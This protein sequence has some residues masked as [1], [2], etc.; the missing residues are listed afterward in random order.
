MGKFNNFYKKILNEDKDQ[1][2]TNKTI[3]IEISPELQRYVL[4]ACQGHDTPETQKDW[5]ELVKE[6]LVEYFNR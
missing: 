6:V 4:A 1:L 2:T 5:Q 3:T